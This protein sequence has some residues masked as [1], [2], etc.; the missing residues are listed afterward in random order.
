MLAE[1]KKGY[2]LIELIVGLTLGAVVMLIGVKA[3][4]TLTGREKS[5]SNSLTDSSHA[6]DINIYL[7]GRFGGTKS[8]NKLRFHVPNTSFN[9][10]GPCFYVN[11]S[12]TNSTADSLYVVYNTAK[13]FDLDGGSSF[14]S[15]SGTPNIK[16]VFSPPREFAKLPEV[17]DFH[18]ISRIQMSELAKIASIE[19]T[20]NPANPSGP[21]LVSSITYATNSNLEPSSP[22]HNLPSNFQATFTAGDSVHQVEMVRIF[23]DNGNLTAENIRLGN[24][25]VLTSS[26][27]EF[28]VKFKNN[29]TPTDCPASSPADSFDH[30]WSKVSSDSKCYE[31]ITSIQIRFVLNEKSHTLEFNV[32]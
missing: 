32:N 9:S 1:S 26:I 5:Q 25:R 10:I 28:T 20:P 30:D 27:S 13:L 17:G 23:L 15:L 29:N 11:S 2:S 8:F 18:A 12:G 24:N 6:Q 19:T 22:T 7:R 21:A 3:I 31:Y 4:S 16:L 14:V